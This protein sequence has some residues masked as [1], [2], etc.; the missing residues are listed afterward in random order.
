MNRPPRTPPGRGLL[1]LVAALAS[2][3][4]DFDPVSKVNS[5]R[6]LASRADHPYAR[7]GDPVQ[8]ELLAV[9]GRPERPTPMGLFWVPVPCLNPPGGTPEG[10]FP[11]LE[12]LFAR[13][14]DLTPQLAQGPKF[15][16]TIPADALSQSTTSQ[17]GTPYGTVF[18]FSMA[19]A[20]HVELTGVQSASPRS[21]PF[22]C[23]DAGGQRLGPDAFV[24][25]F[26]RVFVFAD[27]S[28]ENPVI[29]G[30]LVDG[31]PVDPSTPVVVDRCATPSKSGE[32]ST[33]PTRSV[34]V[35]VPDAS[36]ELDPSYLDPAGN[37]RREAVWVD[38][39]ATAGKL[40]SDVRVLFDPAAGRASSADDFEAPP[41]AGDATLWAVVHDN[42]GGVSWATLPIRTR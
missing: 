13:G 9:D 33:C 42:R 38:Y 22:A 7:P 17:S 1:L 12:A 27:R 6:I 37:A 29:E 19:C 3:G 34:D 23:V 26:S 14:T 24:L 40:K 20:G 10:C 16:F 35:R 8:L 25:A 15:S 18:V 11:L 36:H 30:F 5:V 31:Q 28:N 32:D 2:C 4:N 39:Y 21:S 41:A